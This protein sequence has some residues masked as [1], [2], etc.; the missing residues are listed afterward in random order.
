MVPAHTRPVQVDVIPDQ[1]G[2]PSVIWIQTPFTTPKQSRGMMVSFEEVPSLLT[3]L[4]TATGIETDTSYQPPADTQSS[5]PHALHVKLIDKDS[6]AECPE[7]LD[8]ADPPVI[9]I[10]RA[11]HTGTTPK[12]IG[13]SLDQAAS[14]HDALV[15]A[16]EEFTAWRATSFYNEGTRKMQLGRHREAI[17]DLRQSIEADPRHYLAVFNL[18][19]C[20]D[21]LGETQQAWACYERASQLDSSDPDPFYNM[22]EI[23]FR[24]QALDRA[25]ALCRHALRLFTQRFSTAQWAPHAPWEQDLSKDQYLAD[26]AWKKANAHHLMALIAANQGKHQIAVQSA[27]QAVSLYPGNAEWWL[28]IAQ[29]HQHLGNTPEAQRA[30]ARAIEIDPG[31]ARRAFG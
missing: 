30:I 16:S 26:L 22:A 18:A 1:Q 7:L 23:M 11:S 25:E 28:L 4:A 20:Y 13:I 9:A 10:S 17:S 21:L 3:K 2:N 15:E 8:Y 5:S 27:Q 24:C 29:L 31:I 14:L 12:A 19:M 6:A